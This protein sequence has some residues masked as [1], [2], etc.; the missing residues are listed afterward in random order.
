MENN[1]DIL[2][3]TTRQPEKILLLLLP[4][5]TPQIPPLGISC[6]KS[7]LQ[8]YGYRVTN[9]DINIEPEFNDIYN[10][11]FDLLKEYI[12]VNKRKNFYNIGHDVLRNQMM[13]HLNYKNIG[14]YIE[15]V[16]I[17]IQKNFF[18]N[19]EK[20]PIEELTAVIDEFYTRLK[21]Y[22]LD[23][24]DM[25]KPSVLGISVYSG[26]LPASVFA[27]ALA[28]QRYPEIKTVMG[29][30]IFA[31]ML[32]RHSP[33]FKF[34]LEKSLD[35][36]DK[37]II[38]EGEI[39]FL[40]FLQG[41]LPGSQRVYTIK[42]INE[43][44]LDLSSVDIPDFTDFNPV[45]YPALSYYVSRSCPFRCSF[46]SETLQWGKY[47]KKNAQQVVME[48]KKLYQQYGTQLLLLGDS[49]LNPFITDISREFLKEKQLAIYWDGYLRADKPAG[50]LEN[51]LLWRR[52]G[53]Y[54]VR[55]GLETGSPHLLELMGKKIT[56]EQTRL[57]VTNLAH[58]GIKT[59]TYWVIGHPGETQQDFQQ[60]LDLIGE[61]KSK[62]YE[63]E[64]NPFNYYLTG[65]VNSGA[66]EK[67]NKSIPLYPR[68][69]Q[70]LLMVQTWIMDGEPS[71]EET[72]DRIETF[73]RHCRTLGIPNPY[74]MSEI[75]SADE[76]W[77]KLHKNAA[78]AAVEFKNTGQY[79]DECKGVKKI[80][81]VQ[82][83][84]PDD[85]DFDF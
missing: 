45:F 4:Y 84:Q 20:G 72:Y 2:K 78:P 7:F 55:L 67:E 71:R 17:L 74:S 48:T 9:K 56:T 28:K 83:T 69:V 23:L 14:D 51:T 53:C 34:F 38:G 59:T 61:L 44:I 85:E 31:D 41:D 58:A 70:D 35:Y 12:P 8:P 27:F 18:F 42:D 26:T 5:W 52:G 16:R 79:I 66:W 1:A 32:E 50:D 22:L 11:Y 82:N 6:L 21:R 15:L 73:V 63:A 30:G 24:L 47:R 19:I 68:D 54:R 76:R 40:K 33:N 29:G 43:T 81:M 25:V 36:L 64:C 10:R 80:S 49:L 39:L 62:I 37:I 13:A 60:T 65:Q 77:K 57:A 3:N 75:C 46:C